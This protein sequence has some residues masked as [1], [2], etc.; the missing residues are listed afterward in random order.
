MSQ[1]N[2][3]HDITFSTCDI[4][5][6]VIIM[7]IP[8]FYMW[9]IP[10]RFSALLSAFSFKYLINAECRNVLPQKGRICD[11]LSATSINRVAVYCDHCSSFVFY[12]CLAQNSKKWTPCHLCVHCHRYCVMEF[13][14]LAICPSFLSTRR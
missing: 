8:T 1:M 4:N 14:K 6:I 13:G 11:S 2:P 3:V 12:S 9:S 7:A 5:V 10:S